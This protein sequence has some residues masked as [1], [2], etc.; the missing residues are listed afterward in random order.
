L[1]AYTHGEEHGGAVS[2]RNKEEEGLGSA[3]CRFF[4]EGGIV[5][6]ELAYIK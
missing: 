6:P 1:P 3:G 2:S 5:L 4:F